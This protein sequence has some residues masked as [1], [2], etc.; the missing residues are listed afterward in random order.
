M[1]YYCSN[2]PNLYLF[3]FIFICY[4]PQVNLRREKPSLVAIEALRYSEW[5]SETQL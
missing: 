2:G 5:F 4:P 3:I 1:I